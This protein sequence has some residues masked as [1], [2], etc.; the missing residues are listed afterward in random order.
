MET[1]TTIEKLRNEAARFLR[2]YCIVVNGVTLYPKEIE[3]YYFKKDVFEDDSVHRNKLQKN[4]QYQFY[5]HRYGVEDTAPYKG[6]N[7]PGVD[8]VVSGDDCCFYTLL[9]RTVAFENEK[10][11]IGPNNVLKAIAERTKLNYEKLESVNCELKTID[12]VMCDVGFS[13]RVNLGKTVSEQF[14]AAPLRAVLL[15]EYFAATKYLKKE[16]LVVGMLLKKI[17]Q[18]VVSKEQALE[19]SKNILGYCPS[20]LKT[21]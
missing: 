18:S 17:Q 10:P 21:I 5:V 4:R 11:I 14:K 3:V 12:N 20:A 15:D 1:N 16:K 6:G 13:E 19:H 7:R 9:L 2:Q 8:F